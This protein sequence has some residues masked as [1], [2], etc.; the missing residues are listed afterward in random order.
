MVVLSRLE[1]QDV[2]WNYIN[3]GIWSALEP[4]MAVICACI[5]S[6]RPLFSLS[7]HTLRNVA[8]ASRSKLASTT[9]K[10]TWPGSRSRVSDGMFSQ[11]DEQLDDTRPLGHGV[12]VRGG[13]VN[14]VEAD[15]EAME[16]PPHGIQVKTEV[17]VRTD[18]LEYQDHLF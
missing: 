4:S 5:P 13:R 16:L 1:Q 9:G 17:T 12:S 11:I 6:L 8:S 3:A 10:K 7:A 18:R 2:T 14:D 15:A